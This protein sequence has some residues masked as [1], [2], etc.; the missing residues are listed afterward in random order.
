MGM[1][2]SKKYE[3]ENELWTPEV[4]YIHKIHHLLVKC[5]LIKQLNLK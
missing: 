4:S 1:G 2:M 3:D 5:L